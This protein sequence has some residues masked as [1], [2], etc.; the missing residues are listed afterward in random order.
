MRAS[1]QQTLCNRCGVS[2]AAHGEHAILWPMGARECVC[3]ECFQRVKGGLAALRA[4]WKGQ[5]PIALDDE[6]DGQTMRCL[7]GWWERGQRDNGKYRFTDAQR[8]A[9][10]AH[11][12]AQ[13]RAKVEAG[14]RRDAERAVRVV[15]EC[16]IDDEPWRTW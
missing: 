14:K 5:T 3:R 13:L 16:D 12:S 2:T 7:L 4:A 8:A 1:L 10:S 6:V 15:V 11:W 9:I